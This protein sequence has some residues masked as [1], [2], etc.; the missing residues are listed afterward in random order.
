[1]TSPVISARRHRSHRSKPKHRPTA[2]VLPTY[3]PKH[4][5]ARPESSALVPSTT[6]TD[7]NKEKLVRGWLDDIQVHGTEQVARTH[8]TKDSRPKQRNRLSSPSPTRR[9]PHG[10]SLQECLGDAQPLIRPRRGGRHK[11]R[12]A[13][14]DDS[15]IIAPNRHGR[16]PIIAD[17]DDRIRRPRSSSAA[18]E[19]YS[20]RG[21][22][23][24]QPGADCDE[25]GASL[26]LF[27]PRHNFEKRARH[28]TRNDRYDVVKH[29]DKTK[30]E[31]KKKVKEA[32]AA[33]SQKPKKKRQQ[34]TSAREV[35]DN[36]K[37]HSI[38]TE[39]ITVSPCT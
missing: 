34:M 38:L 5:N 22:R 14:S 11:G 10:L 29:R 4:M 35:M 1:M 26:T 19:S 12:R 39:R 36:F 16:P 31:T 20:E 33:E 21:K 13:L 28:K 24:R 15:S 9:A 32:G 8:G 25:Y 37:S 23:K 3:A 7:G 27:A 6:A 2:H 17:D 30:E 18:E